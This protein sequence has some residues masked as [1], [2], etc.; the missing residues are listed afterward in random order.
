M[1]QVIDVILSSFLA[2]TCEVKVL[3]TRVKMSVI[4]TTL[5]AYTKYLIWGRELMI[6]LRF[7]AIYMLYV[8]VRAILV[9]VESSVCSSIPRQLSTCRDGI[10]SPV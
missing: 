2:S 8:C 4:T 7:P 3:N 10:F 1:L 5:T 6:V 9:R